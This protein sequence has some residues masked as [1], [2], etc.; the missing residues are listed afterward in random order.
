MG[1]KKFN[2]KFLDAVMYGDLEKV[3][4]Y[5]KSGEDPNQIGDNGSP[6]ATACWYGNFNLAKIL[7]E[8]GADVNIEKGSP[9]KNA[10][11]S[12]N[13][14]SKELITYLVNHGADLNRQYSLESD[15]EKASLLTAC[16]YKG[17]I[18]TAY[19]LLELNP[20]LNIKTKYGWT[21]FTVCS[22]NGYKK[23]ASE[24]VKKEFSGPFCDD[25][26]EKFYQ[27]IL[28]GGIFHDNFISQ[29]YCL[30]FSKSKTTPH[31]TGNPK[32]ETLFTGTHLPGCS[33]PPIHLLTLDLSG[34]D[35]FPEEIKKMGKIHVLYTNCQ[36]CDGSD[37]LDFQIEKD[38]RLSVIES[39]EED[40][41]YEEEE[42]IEENNE[43]DD[44]TDEPC[45]S[46]DDYTPSKKITPLKLVQNEGYCDSDI[47]I[48]GLPEWAQYPQ[49]LSCPECGKT[50]FY[51]GS[52]YQFSVPPGAEGAGNHI[53]IFVCSEH[54]TISLVR[55]MT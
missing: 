18:D 31:N 37:Y 47:E 29:K 6:L 51:I 34:I 55:Q 25:D 28:K 26:D 42:E 19:F 35:A 33:N 43:D 2:Q 22:L 30:E 3:K 9:L 20:D 53:Y 17:F 24:I 32:W 13:K 39:E 41:E 15:L 8:A 44:E 38:G 7:V 5:L 21:A 23:L 54:R 4:K 14:R 49:W 36:S 10:V 48:G 45:C 52:I 16:I 50:S 11:L 1:K 12:L 40:E 27:E 46:T